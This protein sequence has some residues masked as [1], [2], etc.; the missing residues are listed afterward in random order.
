MSLS[1]EA[2]PAFPPD[3]APLPPRT[4]DRR[5]AAPDA[6]DER[7]DELFQG[8]PLFPPTGNNARGR[9]Y[10]DSFARAKLTEASVPDLGLRIRLVLPNANE[11]GTTRPTFNIPLLPLDTTVDAIQD[12]W[13][14]G[15]YEVGLCRRSANDRTKAEVVSRRVRIAPRTG[16]EFG[17]NGE[18]DVGREAWPLDLSTEDGQVTDAMREEITYRNEIRASRPERSETS[19]AR[20]TESPDYDY[21]RAPSAFDAPPSHYAG[22]PAEL[23]PAATYRMVGGRLVPVAEAPK[24]TLFDSLAG[25]FAADPVGTTTKLATGAAAFRLVFAQLFPKPP[26]PPTAQEIAA[27]TAAS[28]A[29]ALAPFTQALAAKPQGT[30]PSEVIRLQ[31]EAAR[32]ESARQLAELRGAMEAQRLQSEQQFKLAL[33]QQQHEA[34]AREL[35]H[36]LEAAKN[37]G[38][39]EKKGILA[40]LADL[41]KRLQQGDNEAPPGFFD[42][43]TDFLDTRFGEAVAPF[44]GPSIARLIDTALG[45]AAASTPGLPP[46]PPSV[47]S[48]PTAAPGVPPPDASVAVPGDAAED[49]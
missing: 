39:Q 47:P 13:G 14:P 34:R 41:R 25:Q 2:T 22:H 36:Q 17:P 44:V 18:H 42:R 32:A 23:D 37:A 38:E 21:D 29:Q 26:P 8:C 28:L 46:A 11:D 48:P 3:P 4:R 33:A 45:S 10:A 6:T 7:D 16:G 31:M 19:A 15:C 12:R 20:R 24:P 35:L 30:D 1:E 5:P 43:A 49:A 27:A 40:E 9:S